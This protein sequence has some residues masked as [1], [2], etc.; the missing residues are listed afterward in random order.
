MGPLSGA[1]QSNVGYAH[2]LSG[3]KLRRKGNITS[4]KRT[5]RKERKSEEQKANK[6]ILCR[7]KNARR[8]EMEG[9]L[10]KVQYI[11]GESYEAAYTANRE[12]WGE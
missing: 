9:G 5:A 6:V 3:D 1:S 2:G 7:L 8:E 11:L 4:H 12:R 10:R